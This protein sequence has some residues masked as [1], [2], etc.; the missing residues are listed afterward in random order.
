MGASLENKR[1]DN[2]RAQWSRGWRIR[3]LSGVRH[4]LA[5]PPVA[6]SIVTATKL[7]DTV[8]A[9]FTRSPARSVALVLIAGAV[10]GAGAYSYREIDAELT[11]VELSRRETIAR[12]AAIT[13]SERFG[14]LVDIAVSLAHRPR[15]EQLVAAGRWDEAIQHLRSLPQDLPHIERLFLADVHGTLQADAP[16]L[17][18]ARGKNFAFREW[19]QGVRREWKPYVSPTYLLTATPRLRVFA[20]S[21][22]IR[23]ISD[24]VI[25]I[26]VLQIR[27][28]RMFEWIKTINTGPGEFIYVVDSKGQL[29]FHSRYRDPGHITNLSESP[30]VQKMRVGD[31]GVAVGFEPMEQEDSIVAY[32][33]VPGHGWGLVTQQPTRTSRALAARDAH[34]WWMVIVVYVLVLLLGATSVFLASRIAV[35]SRRAAKLRAANRELEAFSYA[36]SHDLRAPL[37]SIDGFSQALLDDHADRLDKAGQ[38][39]LVRL[40]AATARMGELIEDLLQLSRVTRAKMR[41][42]TVNLSALAESVVEDLRHAEP[43]RQVDV[44]I[45]PGLLA[46]SDAKLLRI[47]LANLLANAWKFT[48]KQPAARIELGVLDGKE[49]R[50]F[51]VRDNGAGFNMAYAGK[52]FGAFQR[53]HAESEFPGTG[54]GLATVQR[55][56]HRHGGRIWAEGAV[57]RGATFYFTLP[58]NHSA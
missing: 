9:H 58:A 28:E 53:L 18:G 47:V 15:V 21:V 8:E 5:L 32:A 45:Q 43:Q 1:I 24:R 2:T 49:G 39:H 35:E 38:K 26:L 16:R 17:P 7:R 11:E 22:P 50:A 12:L 40:R 10:V 56:V 51:F 55:I 48:G 6:G 23:N 19:Y 41:R 52:L 34:L 29:A 36:V 46:E 54:I 42:E 31:H 14:S 20:V 33:L 27:I 30:V 25:G 4:F 57:N 44:V 13:L 37:H 3:L